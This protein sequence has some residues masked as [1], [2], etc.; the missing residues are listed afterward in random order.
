M[1]APNRKEGRCKGAVDGRR[2]LLAVDCSNI[3]PLELGVGINPKLAGHVSRIEL[4]NAGG[5]RDNRPVFVDNELA[6]LI[7]AVTD[8]QSAEPTE[9]ANRKAE[10]EKQRLAKLARKKVDAERQRIAEE[11]SRKLAE[12]RTA[13]QRALAE[14]N[15]VVT[16]IPSIEFGDYHALVIGNND[17]P[18]MNN[19]ENAVQDAK[20]VSSVL[21]RLY[22]FQVRTL[23]NAT[24]SDI[25]G[26]LES[27]RAELTSDSNLLIYYAGHGYVDE[28]TDI[29]YWQPVDSGEISKSNW[30]PNSVVT[31]E[32]KA[33]RAKHVIV[34]A[35]S[36]Y[37]GTL[38]R[39]S[40]K[41]RPT[42]KDTEWYKRMAEKRSRT[43]MVSGGF[44][45]VMDG[46]GG[47]NSVFAKALLDVLRD[48]QSIMDGAEVFERLKRPVALASE[49]TPEYADIRLAGHDGGQFLLVRQD[50]ITEQPSVSDGADAL[51]RAKKQ[52]AIEFGFKKGT[53]QYGNCVMK[54]YK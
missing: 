49:Q 36:C 31:N 7:K 46:G 23:L 21:K 3:P 12:A 34:I 20:D 44:E 2:F 32:L 28:I 52:C 51:E 15:K 16:A 30:I 40:T 50:A 42:A 11:N 43:A 25:F 29:G 24:R 13:E 1:V 45:P 53:V 5:G 35:D 27:Y 17:Y 6:H 39:S 8:R 4:L 22:G 26:A 14:Q 48:N 37:S 18:H 9:L 41:G 33:I 19:L 47:K 38:V 10:A 54:L